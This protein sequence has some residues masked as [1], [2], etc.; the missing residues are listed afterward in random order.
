MYRMLWKGRRGGF[1]EG[2]WECGLRGEGGGLLLCGYFGPGSDSLGRRAGR[3]CMLCFR[4]T[5][6]LISPFAH[7]LVLRFRK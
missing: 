1:G 3:L 5:G 2:E 6:L 4:M 7:V